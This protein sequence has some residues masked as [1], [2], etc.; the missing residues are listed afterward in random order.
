MDGDVDRRIDATRAAVPDR[1]ALDRVDLALQRARALG[2][3]Q[4]EARLS[5]E[6][7]LCVRLRMG[8]VES[9]Q[10]RRETRCKVTVYRGRCRGTAVTSDIRPAAVSDVVEA[11]AGLARHAAE[12]DF[13]GLADAALL[14]AGALPDLDLEHVWT[15]DT[16]RAIGLAEEIEG[17]ALESDPR[18]VNSEGSQVDT[19]HG[20]L[21]YG[22]TH[23]FAGRWAY[24][25]HGMDCTVI[26]GDERGE[27]QQGGWYERT[28][29]PADLP[30]PRALGSRAASRALAR[31][32]ARPVKTC[33]VPV[34][35]EA[36]AATALFRCLA[37]SLLGTNLYRRSSFLAGQLGRALFPERIRIREEP[38]LPKGMGSAPFDE[39]GVAT[40]PK[41]VV[42]DGRL[43]NYLLDSYAA[44]RL[45][46]ESTGNAGGVYNL[47]VQPDAGRPS[48]EDLV[49]QMGE[50]MLVT[51]L[52]GFGTNLVTGSYSQGA[53]GFWVSGGEV[54]YP[55]REVTIAGDLRQM[56]RELGAVGGDVDARGDIHS[57]SVLVGG[58]T[59]AGT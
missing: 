59:V 34:L 4:A 45:G 31:L 7:G 42:T 23:G 58:M 56:F 41:D 54:R 29:D 21:A 38:L 35:F 32:G 51:E 13:A 14:P 22:N 11:A 10:H 12:D 44:R 39:E 40:R 52:M 53:A 46:L 6:T 55:V 16:R 24:S 30:A 5:S 26:A 37:Q 36:P 18:I 1:I 57:G 15:L 27:M 17:H 49:G 48:R 50:G 28:R 8:E 47:T 33:R 43:A 25:C 3:D 20:E 9:V 2:C 19:L